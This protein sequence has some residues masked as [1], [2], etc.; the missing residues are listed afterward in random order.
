MSERLAPSYSRKQKGT[1]MPSKED[2]HRQIEDLLHTAGLR[3]VSSEEVNRV[4][5]QLW[6]KASRILS[7]DQADSKSTRSTQYAGDG[8]KHIETERR[9]IA[10]TMSDFGSICGKLS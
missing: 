2:I 6:I 4:E 5:Y 10:C 9:E 3:P 8:A 1:I 7:S